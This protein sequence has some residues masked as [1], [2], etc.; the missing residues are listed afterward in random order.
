VVVTTVVVLDYDYE[1]ENW[2]DWEIQ[3][4]A[5]LH[6]LMEM[7]LLVERMLDVPHV[8]QQRRQILVEDDL[9]LA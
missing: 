5:C 3:D 7:A 1:N 6:S 8:G 4:F 9:G 2:V